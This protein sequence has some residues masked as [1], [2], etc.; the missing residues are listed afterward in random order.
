MYAHEPWRHSTQSSCCPFL[1][2]CLLS[3]SPS[4]CHLPAGLC[5]TITLQ[6]AVIPFIL[7]SP[8]CCAS[9]SSTPPS[10]C[11]LPSPRELTATPAPR[12]TRPPLSAADWRR[13]G[14]RCAAARPAQLG[15]FARVRWADPGPVFARVRSAGRLLPVVMVATPGAHQTLISKL[16]ACAKRSC[17]REVMR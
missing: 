17:W 3:L 14:T 16:A 9:T 15:C 8:S 6:S 5:S 11:S 7:P 12:P 4:A 10:S 2:A 13:L 1:S